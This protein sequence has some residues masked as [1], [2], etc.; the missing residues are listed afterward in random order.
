MNL[1]AKISES[2]GWVSISPL[3]IVAENEFGNL[4]IEDIEGRFWRLCPEELSCLVIADSEDELS[5]VRSDPDFV[6]EWE[7]RTLVEEARKSLGDLSDGRKFC[8]KIPGIFGGAYE[9][10]NIA[11]VP[12]E[13]LI[14]ISGDLAFQCKDIPD[15]TKVI[16]EVVDE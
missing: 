12:F 16:L 2:W 14:S 7:M 11:I 9:I 13:E 3:R 8:L 5:E 4:I 6:A 10:E 15:G 1:I